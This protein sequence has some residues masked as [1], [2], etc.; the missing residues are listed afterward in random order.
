[1]SRQLT[2]EKFIEK[3]IK[4]HGNEYDYTKTVYVRNNIK[5]LITCKVHGDF[6]VTPNDHLS[7]KRKCNKCNKKSNKTIITCKKCGIAKIANK[8]N[9]IWRNDRKTWDAPCRKC[10]IKVRKEYSIKNKDKANFKSKTWYKN[11]KDRK[12]KY[13]KDRYLNNIN[14]IREYNKYYRKNNEN[15]LK[16]N[17]KNIITRIKSV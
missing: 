4:I 2:T 10:C 16:N 17:K 9:F 1:M 8:E 7:K 6:S 12:K 5:V 14:E 13:D 15:K 3:A 11:N